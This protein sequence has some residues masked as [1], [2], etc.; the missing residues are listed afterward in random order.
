MNTPLL[1]AWWDVLLHDVFL[2]F[3][4]LEMRC[5]AWHEYEFCGFKEARMI[6]YSVSFLVL[7]IESILDL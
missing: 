5:R 2:E 6:Q 1:L 7:I 3:C 4:I